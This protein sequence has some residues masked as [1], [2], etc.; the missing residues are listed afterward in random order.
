M[1]VRVYRNLNNGLV[2]IMCEKT[3]LVLGYGQE[4]M[5]DEVDFIVNESGRQRVLRDKCKNVHAYARGTIISATDFLPLKGRK[6]SIEPSESMLQPSERIFYN[7]YRSGSFTDLEGR[8][9]SRAN[10]CFINGAGEIYAC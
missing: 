8:R 10:R 4:I 7:P 6:I 9:V 3:R 2:S 5:L 1:K